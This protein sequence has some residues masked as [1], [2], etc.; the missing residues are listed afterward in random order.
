MTPKKQRRADARISFSGRMESDWVREL[1]SVVV[2][3]A[4]GLIGRATFADHYVV[5]SGSMEPT[6]EIGDRILVDKRAY[7]FRLPLSNTYIVEGA[8][9]K[10]GDVVVLDSPETGD[11][12]LKRVV[13]GPQDTVSILG[14]RVVLNGV[15]A[16]IESRDGAL[17]ELLESTEHPVR[18]TGGGGP[19]FGPVRLPSKKY[20]VVGD[21]RGLS[22]DGRSFGFVDR[23]TIL[24]RAEIVYF[25][26]GTFTWTDL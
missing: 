11:V 23:E 18:L 1:L 20:L 9:P 8:D 25:R 24:G 7:G 21:N 10:T 12:L 22:H 4:I 15:A 2:V 13:A 16:P 14:G 17:L 26:K 6:V 5:P 19:E 3:V